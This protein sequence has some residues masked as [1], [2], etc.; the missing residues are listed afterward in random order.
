ME[1]IQKDPTESPKEYP[2][3]STKKTNKSISQRPKH[4]P[5]IEEDFILKVASNKKLSCYHNQRKSQ[6]ISCY[7]SFLDGE[8]IF[9][10]CKL[11]GYR[12]YKHG[13]MNKTN[14]PV[15]GTCFDKWKSIS[16]TCIHC[17]G[18]CCK[19]E[20]KK[21]DYPFKFVGLDE[22]IDGE[23]VKMS[24]DIIPI[25]FR[26]KKKSF[27]Q[28]EVD[29]EIKRSKKKEKIKKKLLVEL[30]SCGFSKRQAKNLITECSRYRIKLTLHLWKN[31]INEVIRDENY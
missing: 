3:E 7:E 11:R 15:C 30:V 5:S 9:I 12:R 25:R 26:K 8:M 21:K 28:R 2:K 22:L 17:R 31:K 13:V 16:D 6:C 24:D 20:I 14:V 19:Q 1:T 23:W 4:I 27:A 29:I 18:H 10:N